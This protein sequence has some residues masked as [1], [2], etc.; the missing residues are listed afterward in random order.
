MKTTKKAIKAKVYSLL[1]SLNGKKVVRVQKT[2]DQGD[3]KVYGRYVVE[4]LRTGLCFYFLTKKEAVA[5][6]SKEIGLLDSF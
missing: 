1:Q 2:L 4:S 3:V 5:F 6:F